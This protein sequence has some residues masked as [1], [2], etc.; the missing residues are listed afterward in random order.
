MTETPKYTALVTG[1][2]GQWWA[3]SIP[4]LGPDAR[5]QARRLDEVEDE[6]RDYIATTL[7]VPPSTVDVEMQPRISHIAAV[8]QAAMRWEG[9]L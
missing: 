9:V 6:A 5:T 1:R 4:E 8:H 3:L 7:D 2:E